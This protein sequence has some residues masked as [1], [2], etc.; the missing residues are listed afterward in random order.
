MAF[1]CKIDILVILDCEV[2][3]RILIQYNKLEWKREKY[4]FLREV[5]DTKCFTEI[6]ERLG[7]FTLTH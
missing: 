6:F 4:N 2:Q 5:G 7:H 1:F 3:L